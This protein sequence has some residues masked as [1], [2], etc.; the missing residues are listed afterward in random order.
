[1]PTPPKMR[2]IICL[3]F[4]LLM[5][6]AVIFSLRFKNI[7]SNRTATTVSTLWIIAKAQLP[8]ETNI[9]PVKSA[10]FKASPKSNKSS[11]FTTISPEIKSS[12]EPTSET[13]PSAPRL[14][15]DALRADAVQQEIKREKSPVELMNE[16]R[17]KNNS[18][19]ARVE[20]GAAKAQRADCRTAYAGGTPILAA[21]LI[22]A[23]LIRDKGCKF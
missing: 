8:K 22:A 16:A 23:D 10:T 3:S 17:L 19:E 15:L 18:L 1:M 13:A 12:S 5:H 7:Y 21:L 14:D 4:V 11:K 2:T 20:E 9:E 6:I